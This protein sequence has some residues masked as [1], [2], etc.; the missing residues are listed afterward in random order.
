MIVLGMIMLAYAFVPLYRIFCQV[1]GFGGTI[2]YSR[3]SA[4]YLG[5]K[6]IKIS[7]DANIADDLNW[8]FVPLNRDISLITGQNAVI[9]YKAVN[10]STEDIIGTA[11]YNVTPHAA[12]KY[13]NKIECFCFQEQLLKKGEEAIMPVSFFIDPEIEKD[14]DLDGLDEITLSYSFYKVK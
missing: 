7:F 13:F 5:S 4:G 10:L 3:T 8:Q 14:K 11:I 2:Q 12:G 1:T 6:V 9:F